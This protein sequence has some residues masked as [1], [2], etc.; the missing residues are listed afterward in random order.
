MGFYPSCQL[1]C[2]ARTVT[3]NSGEFE[4]QRQ[5]FGELRAL[6]AI[7]LRSVSNKRDAAVE[8]IEAEA[9]GMGIGNAL[10]GKFAEMT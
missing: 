6:L 1:V 10:D 5:R 7:K 8:N 4:A 9:R 3:A 2:W